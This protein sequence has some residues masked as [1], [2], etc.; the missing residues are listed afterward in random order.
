MLS[1]T[2]ISDKVPGKLGGSSTGD[3]RILQNAPDEMLPEAEFAQAARF[4]TSSQ[5]APSELIEMKIKMKIK[6]S[7]QNTPELDSELSS[8]EFPVSSMFSC[9]TPACGFMSIHDLHA[10]SLSVDIILTPM[11]MHVTYIFRQLCVQRFT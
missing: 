6:M 9:D 11:T 3:T 5:N 7:R 2:R 10:L 1:C 4:C 8:P